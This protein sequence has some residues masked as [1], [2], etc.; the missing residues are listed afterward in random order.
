MFLSVILFTSMTSVH[1][2]AIGF[3]AEYEPS[4]VQTPSIV[5]SALINV[6]S[7]EQIVNQFVAEPQLT[8]VTLAETNIE[9]ERA[10]EQSTEQSSELPVN[11]DESEPATYFIN[12][13]VAQMQVDN[14]FVAE[15]QV[16]D[17]TDTIANAEPV[18]ASYVEQQELANYNFY[19]AFY[20]SLIKEYGLVFNADDSDSIYVLVQKKQ[21]LVEQHQQAL[22]NQPDNFEISLEPISLDDERGYR[23]QLKVQL[24]ETNS[25]AETSIPDSISVNFTGGQSFI[26]S[27][28]SVSAQ[29]VDLSPLRTPGGTVEVE[30]STSLNASYDKLL[31][32]IFS[33]P[34]YSG[35]N[36]FRQFTFDI[37]PAQSLESTNQLSSYE[38]DYSAYLQQ[39]MLNQYNSLNAYY[40]EVIKGYG[41]EF[42]AAETDTVY[43]LV[44]K[45]RA[46]FE[47][48]QVLQASINV[49]AIS[50]DK[51][52]GYRF[53]VKVNILDEY[54]PYIQTLPDQ[55]KLSFFGGE[56]KDNTWESISSE[57]ID[58][59]PLKTPGGTVDVEVSANL[60][61]TTYDQLLVKTNAVSL[62]AGNLF[63]SSNV[64]DLPSAAV[65][66]AAETTDPDQQAADQLEHMKFVNEYCDQLIKQFG[67]EFSSSLSDT[68][69][70]WMLITEKINALNKY[71]ESQ[72]TTSA[73]LEL[74]EP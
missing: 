2:T 47:Q 72:S 39:N 36:V 6:A 1:S 49:Q 17:D 66:V 20:D 35:R 50:L 15:P 34:Q 43:D 23:F 45:K 70:S 57:T 54:L 73:D 10:R 18:N 53:Q 56:S 24:K 62:V 11:V 19:N 9:P 32:Q 37:A 48:Y 42:T 40:D 60:N 33:D 8:D 38:F 61:D 55:L 71:Y 68:E 58:L 64:M 63:S 74:S 30:V 22:A 46:L 28:W 14:Q 51:D 7:D 65:N 67:I 41:L 31:V 3:T 5:D 29:Q 69:L 26:N 16:T 44:P 13:I 52:N 25:T 27:W 12:P 21:S 4:S 59:S